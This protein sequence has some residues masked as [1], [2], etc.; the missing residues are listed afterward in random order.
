MRHSGL[1]MRLTTTVADVLKRAI[2]IKSSIL[3]CFFIMQDSKKYVEY[4]SEKSAEIAILRKHFSALYVHGSYWINLAGKRNNGWRAFHRE[5][6]LAKDFLFTH[7]VIHPGAATGCKTKQEGIEC[8]ARALNKI[9]AKEHDIK[10]ILENAAHGKMTVGGDLNDFKMLLSLSDY[11]E[12]LSFCIDT[13]HAHSYGYDLLSPEGR[14]FFMQEI[15]RCIG[16][17]RLAL[18]HLNDT[19][20]ARGSF[21]DQHAAVGEGVLGN[22]TLQY[23]MNHS[24]FQDKPLILELPITYDEKQN[25]ILLE[26]VR[27]WEKEKESE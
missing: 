22:E 7:M 4:S 2:E 10:L 21:I 15:E 1:H 3:Q 26:R 25:E 23:V 14:T 18:L 12:K 13:A 16:K 6:A 24:L 11:P 27:S 5:L 19:T 9:L 20:Q 17:E 8:L